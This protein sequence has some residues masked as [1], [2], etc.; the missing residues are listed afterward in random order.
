MQQRFSAANGDNGRPE[1]RQAVDSA[2]HFLR[3]HRGGEVV[4]LVAI[5][6]GEIAAPGRNNVGEN[7][8]AVRCQ[9]FDYHS[10]FS[11]P[12]VELDRT[13]HLKSSKIAHSNCE[14]R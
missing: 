10:K 5:S 3:R 13:L 11:S 4:V 2:D 14:I 8:M 6:A 1:V 9:S 12:Q 7:D